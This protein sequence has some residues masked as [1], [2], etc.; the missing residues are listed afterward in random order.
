M[1]LR[2]LKENMKNRTGNKV[3]KTRFGPETRFEIGPL[4]PSPVPE[5]GPAENDL[6][7]LKALK[8]QI[9]VS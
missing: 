7:K 1:Q 2:I 3:V 4:A 9:S 5:R 6:E 8:K